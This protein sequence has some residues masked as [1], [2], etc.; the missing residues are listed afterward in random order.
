MEVVLS[1]KR[2]RELIPFSETHLR[3]MEKAGTFPKRIR[4]GPG[5]VG[6]IASEVEAWLDEKRAERNG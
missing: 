6:Y 3:R 5:R 1:K 4:L 2:L